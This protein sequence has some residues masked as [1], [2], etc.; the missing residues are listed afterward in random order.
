MLTSR[1]L[2]FAPKKRKPTM[3]TKTNWREAIANYGILFLLGAA[4][5]VGSML[6]A[7]ERREDGPDA[8]SIAAVTR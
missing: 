8:V 3:K 6:I 1:A 2:K 5:I 4:Y 7:P